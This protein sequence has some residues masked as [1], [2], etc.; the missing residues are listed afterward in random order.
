MVEGPARSGRGTYH[1]VC[2]THLSRLSEGDIVQAV[3]QPPSSPF[4][5][6]EDPSVPIVM[7]GPGT[8]LAP[9]RGFIQAR[10]A[11]KTDG[12]DL[13]EAMLFFGCRHPDQDFIYEE[14]LKAAE[15]D[16]V[17]ALHTAF[18]RAQ[19]ERV[20]VQ[21]VLRQQQAQVWRLI[22]DG[23]IIYV[24]GDGASMEPDVRR[25]LT[26]LY[27]EQADVSFAEAEVWMEEFAASGR[28][29]LDVWAG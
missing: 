1:G 16:G 26:K 7:I 11:L 5:L 12:A 18:S 8:G 10:R 29:V 22:E 6:P 27:A 25:T 20:Y 19:A 13:G 14:E 4:R 24:C 2:S 9:F 15:A 28:Y 3:V 21:D 23:A 17:I